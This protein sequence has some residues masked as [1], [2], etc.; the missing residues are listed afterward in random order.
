MNVSEIIKELQKLDKSLPVCFPNHCDFPLEVREVKESKGGYVPT[1]PGS[2]G[3]EKDK[4][5]VMFH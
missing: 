5:Y 3:V 1:R 2:I 4:S